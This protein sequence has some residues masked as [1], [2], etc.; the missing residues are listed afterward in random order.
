M[1]EEVCKNKKAVVFDFDNTLYP[2]KDYLYQVYYLIGQFIEYQEGHEH[3]RVTRFLVDEFEKSGRKNLF[4]KLIERYSLAPEYM[5]NCLRLL[6]TAKLPLK[7]VLFENMKDLLKKL[8]ADEKKIFILTNG[9]PEQQ[10]NKIM[11]VEWHGLQ[12][13][14]QVYFSN[15]FKPKPAPD[16][17]IHLL[18][19]NNLHPED[20]VFIGDSEEDSECAKAS[21]VE[22]FLIS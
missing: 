6:R 19:E 18:K 2:E 21:K 7:L 4:D 12:H 8:I 10:F 15:E 22:F 5:E 14:I 13:H 16:G 20:V 11:Q 17:M 3:E 9:N 1:F